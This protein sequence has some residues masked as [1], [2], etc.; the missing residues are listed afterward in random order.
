MGTTA[1][2]PVAAPAPAGAPAPVTPPPAPVTPEPKAP[3]TAPK[4]GPALNRREARQQ[5]LERA[6]EKAP[7]A[8]AKPPVSAPAATPVADPAMPA[9]AAAVPVAPA[10]IPEVQKFEVVL[11]ADHPSA[12]GKERTVKFDNQADA[13]AM[14][15]M[16]NA[17]FIRAKELE[18][19]QTKADAYELSQL[20]EETKR[21]TLAKYRET[22]AF[23]EAEER[24]RQIQQAEVD[25]TIPK[26]SAARDWQITV[27]E[28]EKV[29]D[30]A[31][32]EVVAKREDAK[33]DAAAESWIDEAYQRA[34]GRIPDLVRA[35][36]G[37][38]GWFE[39]AI[40]SF[41][42]E[43]GLGHIQIPEAS[44][45]HEEFRQFLAGVLSRQ[46]DVQKALQLIELRKTEATAAAKAAEDTRARE[47]KAA[48][49]KAVE[50]FKKSTA[51]QRTQAPPHPLGNLNAPRTAPPTGEPASQDGRPA[52]ASGD[53][54]LRREG[55]EAARQRARER[56]G[57]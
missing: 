37:Y 7:V 47:L 5:M 31:V 44:D 22:P 43:L 25:G 30:A 6:K 54:N 18:A 29:V 34:D 10:A 23:K 16:L 40:K 28:F 56:F 2:E 24:N 39:Q 57:G 14:K 52:P 45:G 55:R 51:A 46:G 48:T 19:A 32:N 8:L 3:E 50:D 36:P 27:A 9:E 53:Q 21:T 13:E 20:R 1:V 49:D 38:R 41:N 15:S 26:G 33:T 4:E 42:S 17:T 11:P 12:R 35:L